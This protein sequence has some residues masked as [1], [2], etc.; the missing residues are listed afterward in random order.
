MS[1]VPEDL[2]MSQ[3]GK[4]S[5]TLPAVPARSSP[6]VQA[7][8]TS[9]PG[10]QTQSLTAPIANEDA[11]QP[12]VVMQSPEVPYPVAAPLQPG[13]PVPTQN[14]FPWAPLPLAP[15]EV[16]P[17]PK[18]ELPPKPAPVVWEPLPQVPIS[19]PIQIA[20]PPPEPT[21]EPEP[22][23]APAPKSP[24]PSPPVQLAV[25]P[26]PVQPPPAQQ[27]KPVMPPEV[28]HVDITHIYSF[29]TREVWRALR[30]SKV[31]AAF[32]FG[33]LALIGCLAVFLLQNSGLSIYEV[34]LIKDTLGL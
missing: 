32:L 28:P 17:V 19:K 7:D 9:P 13:D 10:V 29:S 18:L 1:D 31:Y 22:E 4:A 15:V 23:P 14:H 20:A 33:S 24:P 16:A 27:Q 12:T 3:L 25:A 21:P 6:P 26:P 11:A 5:S 2:D 30:P 8:I 34:P